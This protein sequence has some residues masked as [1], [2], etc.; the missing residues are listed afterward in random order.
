MKNN[1]FFDLFD[2][3]QAHRAPNAAT[4]KSKNAAPSATA[5]AAQ[6]WR[7]N[8][9]S[10]QRSAVSYTVPGLVAPEA[11]PSGWTCWATVYTMLLNWK[12]GSSHSIEQAVGAIG[13][14]Y[15]EKVRR[16]RQQ[17]SHINGLGAAEKNAFLQGS[18]IQ[19]EYP[20]SL[21]ID[22]WLGLLQNYGPIWVTTDEDLSQ[23]GGIHARIMKGIQGDGTPTGTNLQII[24]P[25]GGRE[26][27]ERFDAFERKYA[28]GDAADGRIQ[29]VHW[30]A[31]ASVQQSIWGRQSRGFSTETD[32]SI[33]ENE[34]EDTLMSYSSSTVVGAYCTLNSAAT[35]STA[36]FSLNEFKCKDGT[37]VP[38]S[39]RG[40]VQHLM[41]QLQ[42]LRDHVGRSIRV[43]SGF[44]TVDY[45]ASL[46]GTAGQSRH[47]CGQAADIHIEGMT[48]REVKTTIEQLISQG[49][50]VQGGI[51]LYPTFVHYDT[52]LPDPANP[53]RWYGRGVTP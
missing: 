4:D 39:I 3:M 41:N 12:T 5:A 27:L 37:D 35:A 11:Q 10:Y 13:A 46:E 34:P 33:E 36:N 1:R 51:G 7:P 2:E 22:G 16:D 30:P 38:Q 23:S 47:C 15:A 44:R 43:N 45:N 18:G 28:F 48:P 26:Y 9:Y 14:Q 50:M 24:D 21:S 52:H 25:A 53:R 6:S 40:N 8:R 20:Q 31:G 19:W 49:K 42:A 17:P 32:Q 29:I